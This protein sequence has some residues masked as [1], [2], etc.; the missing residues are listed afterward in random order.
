MS[1]GWYVQWGQKLINRNKNIDYTTDVKWWWIDFSLCVHPYVAFN[2]YIRL[3]FYIFWYDWTVLVDFQNDV[4]YYYSLHITDSHT[5]LNYFT[6]GLAAVLQRRVHWPRMVVLVRVSSMGQ[7]EL[8][9]ILLWIII[10]SNLKL[11]SCV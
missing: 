10:I 1:R 4:Q 8:F 6:H 9:P 11:C 2:R 5:H 7:I 3:N